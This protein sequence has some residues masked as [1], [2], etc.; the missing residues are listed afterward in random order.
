MTVANQV[1]T[2]SAFTNFCYFWL[3]PLALTLGIIA[4]AGD[5][6]SVQHFRLS[7][8]LL[9]LLLPHYPAAEIY[10]LSLMLRKVGHFLAYAALCLSYLRAIQ[11]Q[12]SLAGGASLGLALAVCTVVALADEGRQFFYISRTSSFLDVLLD[13]SGAITAGLLWLGAQHLRRIAKP[14][15]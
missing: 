1:S 8:Y 5:L 2:L 13:L 15:S 6:G 4:F 9:K 7:I 11:H 10:R 14:R 12:W 3:P